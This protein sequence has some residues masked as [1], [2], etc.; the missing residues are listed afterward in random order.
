LIKKELIKLIL[1]PRLNK[2]KKV[3]LFVN[4][5]VSNLFGNIKKNEKKPQKPL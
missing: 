2:N 5:Y 1:V 4:L 3:F